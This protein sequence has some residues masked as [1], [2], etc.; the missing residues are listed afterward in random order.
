MFCTHGLRP[1]FMETVIHLRRKPHTFIEC[2]PVEAEL[3]TELPIYYHKAINDCEEEWSQHRKLIELGP[4]RSIAQAV[5]A[6][7]AYFHVDFMDG[8]KSFAHHI[9]DEK[10]WNRTFGKSVV[11]AFCLVVI[12]FHSCLENA[13]AMYKE[14]IALFC[15]AAVAS[16]LGAILQTTL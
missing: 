8:Q 15:C 3:A 4:E 13:K 7:F 6:G 2:I 5:P 12:S 14:S 16:A 1:V 10:G 11:G 9:E